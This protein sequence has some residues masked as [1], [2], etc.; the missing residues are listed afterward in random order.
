MHLA[1]LLLATLPLALD[2]ESVTSSNTALAVISVV[3]M[4]FGYLLLAALWYFVFSARARERRDK[5]N[6]RD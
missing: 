4:V 3:S 5:P 6:K 2:G 1:M